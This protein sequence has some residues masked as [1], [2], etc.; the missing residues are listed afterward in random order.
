MTSITLAA[1]KSHRFLCGIASV[2]AEVPINKPP[3]LTLNG[4]L[5]MQLHF[6]GHPYSSPDTAVET[7]ELKATGKYRGHQVGFRHAQ[8]Q[9]RH[10]A[11]ALRYR[12]TSYLR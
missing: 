6:L 5:T 9:S 8:P 2:V 7:V 3:P 10:A 1:R 12:G 11:I 4:N